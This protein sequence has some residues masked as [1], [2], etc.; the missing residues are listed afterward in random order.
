MDQRSRRES[1]PQ[2]AIKVVGFRV[3]G[4]AQSPIPHA[5]V[6][7]DSSH[8][9]VNATSG[10]PNPVIIPP[11][12]QHDSPL[13]R[14]SMDVAAVLT[15][16]R[17]LPAPGLTRQTTLPVV[18]GGPGMSSVSVRDA[19]R[20]PTAVRS[21]SAAGDATQPVS[22]ARL[23]LAS[24]QSLPPLGGADQAEIRYIAQAAA[25]SLSPSTIAAAAAASP[26]GSLPRTHASRRETPPLTPR[27]TTADQVPHPQLHR[28]DK[29]AQPPQALGQSLGQSL[30]S[31]LDSESFRR[32]ESGNRR[33][34][35]DLPM[36]A[37]DSGASTD[38][39]QSRASGQKEDKKPAAPAAPA[40]AKDDKQAADKKPAGAPG[41]AAPPTEDKK[42]TTKAERRAMQERQRAEKAKAKAAPAGEAPPPS[43]QMQP[44]SS[45]LARPASDAAA[46]VSK[47]GSGVSRPAE[48]RAPKVSR[49]PR[50]SKDKVRAGRER[51]ATTL[52]STE[53]F[54]HLQQYK[55]VTVES[56]LAESEVAAKVHPKILQLGLKYADGSVKGGNA[57]CIA[58][59]DAFRHL[60]RDYVT[61]AGKVLQRDL[62]VQ[63]NTAIQFLVECRPLSVSMGNAIKFFKLQV[64]K[65][66]IAL[67][68]SEAKEHLIGIID[69]Y[70]QEKILFA[71][72]ILVQNAVQKVYNDD[73]ILTYAFSSVVLNILVQAWQAG[74]RFRVVVVDSRPQL[75]GRE[76]LRRLLKHGISCSYIYINALSYIMTEV[77]KVFLGASA[78]LS[79]GTVISR[80]GSAGVAM[81]S[82]VHGK[83]VI[84]CCETYKFHERV[85][86]DAITSNELGDPEQL[87]AVGTRP[88]IKDLQ[89][90]EALPQLGLLNLTY[91]AMPAEYV[92]LIVTE[93]G[94]IPPTSVP[95]IL[96]EYR[97]EPMM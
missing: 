3:E 9:H 96:R 64:G 67:P 66:D 20:S 41:P 70:I 21:P 11:S 42:A 44:S 32:P 71:D 95:V 26:Y 75:E 34:S 86:L 90:W 72:D 58:M 5:N 53:M 33:A 46:A 36:G 73:V 17:E 38:T 84:I 28:C 60:I 52:K 54:A 63:L 87:V 7:S 12:F 48:D 19:L 59:L 85:Q 50:V 30:D 43:V 24:S 89:G 94:S 8:E 27:R 35:T 4:V 81:M 93:F 97:Q 57:R 47:Q 55:R 62:A 40:P 77:T 80:V 79:N 88:L 16:T 10:S 13:S 18:R 78:V 39:S 6:L 69:T 56:A 15:T 68:E 31:R 91:D 45:N 29:P 14:R 92:T 25:E 22:P 1:G 61:P 76:L 83:P 49:T 65:L 74:K 23:G 37:S 2:P 82:S 51:G